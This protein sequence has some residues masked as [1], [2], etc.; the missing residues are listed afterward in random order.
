M[1]DQYENGRQS[2]DETTISHS[3]RPLSDATDGTAYEEEPRSTWFNRYSEQ[4]NEAIGVQRSEHVENVNYQELKI[5]PSNIGNKP[6]SKRKL[7]Y[8][9]TMSYCSRCLLFCRRYFTSL[10]NLIQ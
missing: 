9:K 2:G 10:R 8:N 6:I 4:P 1:N 3:I 7:V 5:P